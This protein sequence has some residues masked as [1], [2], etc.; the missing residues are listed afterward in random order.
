[1]NKTPSTDLILAAILGTL[2]IVAGVSSVFFSL[3]DREPLTSGPLVAGIVGAMLILAAF[4]S[5]RPGSWQ[6]VFVLV[7]NSLILVFCI[8]LALAFLLFLIGPLH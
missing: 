8:G 6:K 2:A 3:R 7:R 4:M 1:V 5:E